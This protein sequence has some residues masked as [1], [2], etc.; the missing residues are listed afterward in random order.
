MTQDTRSTTADQLLDFLHEIGHLKNLPRTGWRF[1]GIKHSESIADHSYRMA[2]LCMV[3]GDLLRERGLSVD[4]DKTIRMALLHEI[5]EA[6][7]G[8][9]P[10]PALQ[11]LTE[12][13]KE[14]AE[15]LAA[16]DM[17]QPLGTIGKRYM[18]TWE[19]FERSESTE[20]ILVRAADKLELLI[21]VYEYEKQ[22]HRS[23]D[24]FWT[25]P[26]NQRGFDIHPLLTEIMERLTSRRQDV[27][28]SAVA[29]QTR[30]ESDNA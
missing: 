8:D 24:C 16:E 1:H 21:Q 14:N 18:A 13:V 12:S 27:I 29:T 9:I 26:W 7:I 5:A 25:N 6:R 4:T 20:A 23:L 30:G 22:G 3:L 19:E 17:L 2:L 15:K 10:F 28:P 11:Y